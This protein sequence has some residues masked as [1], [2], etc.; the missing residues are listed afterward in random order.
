MQLL[1]ADVPKK[2][3][4][5]GEL[6][7]ETLDPMGYMSFSPEELARMTGRSDN[8]V[9]RALDAVR[10]LDPPG[11]A[12]CSLGECM[13]LQL[14]ALGCEDEV[15]YMIADGHMDL[16]AAGKLPAI[17]RDLH[18]PLDHVR[19]AAETIRKLDP[20]PGSAFDGRPHTEYII[21]DIICEG[22]RG[23]YAIT[24]NRAGVPKLYILP[25]YKKMI[26][27]A[28]GDAAT[29]DYLKTRLTSAVNLMKNI[30]RRNDTILRVAEAIV[31]RQREFIDGG[32][33]YL[34]PM[35]LSSVAEDIGMHASTVSRAVHGK[36]IQT[37]A[38]VF[39]L[40]KLFSSGASAQGHSAADGAGAGGNGE[41]PDAS[42]EKEESA[43]AGSVKARIREFIR[44]EDPHAPLSD[45]DI[46]KM[47]SSCG[48]DVSRRV[49]A[50]YRT[51]MDI[52][53][54]Q[55]RRRYS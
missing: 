4:E 45:M 33:R 43:S 39:E 16:L 5:L 9:T 46:T 29:L 22:G 2:I 51:A 55:Q 54:S 53:T 38:G 3:R 12:A 32:E 36:Y 23:A 28:G 31:T 34:K 30:E 20:K 52:P 27:K 8:D 24:L 44:E 19:R 21:P 25:H 47:L 17:A 11:V 37:P 42:N 50:K 10:S 40:R 48:I 7:I 18:V 6:I 13:R 15:A 1:I 35:R 14:D 49:V 41:G 26:D